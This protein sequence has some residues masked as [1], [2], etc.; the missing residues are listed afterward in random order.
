M[1]AWS[2]ILARKLHS[3]PSL[4]LHSAGHLLPIVHYNRMA[5]HS[6]A[7]DHLQWPPYLTSETHVSRPWN[8]IL[9]SSRVA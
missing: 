3:I 8:G 5:R 6:V 2:C 1:I 9:K 7:L 4:L